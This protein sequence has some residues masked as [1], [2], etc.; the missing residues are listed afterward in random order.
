MNTTLTLP[1]WIRGIAR[2]KAAPPQPVELIA[3][4]RIELTLA[5]GD[6]LSVLAGEVILLRSPQWLGET[7]LMPAT[8]RLVEGDQWR[9]GARE[10]ITL[11]ANRASCLVQS[12]R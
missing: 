10:R 7:L 4:Q 3:G 11:V 5:P 6:A 8:C 9:G 2:T 1:P 12:A